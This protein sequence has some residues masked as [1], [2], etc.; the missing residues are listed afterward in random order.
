M[1][2]TL[3]GTPTNLGANL[4]AD[5]F[6]LSNQW[7]EKWQTLA[8]WPATENTPAAS[9][10]PLP[11]KCNR[12]GDREASGNLDRSIHAAM[13]RAT[14][15]ISPASL[16]LAY[17]DWAV[18]LAVSPGK[19]LRL[20]ENGARQLTQFANYS[21]QA[22]LGTTSTPC[23]EAADH[24]K[25]FNEEAWQR[26]PFNVYSQAFL[27]QQQWWQ[28]AT[29]GIA[30]VSAHDEQ[31]VS[32][33]ARQLLDMI[34]PVNF[35]AT[36]PLVLETTIKEHG[37]NLIRGMQNFQADRDR[38]LIGRNEQSVAALVLHQQIVALVALD[39]ALDQAA[40]LP[41]AVVHVDH[42]V[43]LAQIQH[44]GD[45]HAARHLAPWR[46]RARRTEQ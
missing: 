21:P 46:D 37:L 26:W 7:L 17:L 19:W 28:H 23:I 30:G 10:L 36:N 4:A 15:G 6:D 22:C 14:L 42:I 31:V 9:P 35:G 39:G 45:R 38:T 34:S 32:F 29:T 41:D 43:E 13:A 40:I 11:V 8:S 33:V 18:H 44:R 24:D 16:A 20:A 5:V 1:K 3:P 12:I 27:L 2:T 25:R